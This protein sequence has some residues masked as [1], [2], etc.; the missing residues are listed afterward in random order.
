MKIVEMLMVQDNAKQKIELL[1]SVFA[2]ERLGFAIFKGL[3]P[4]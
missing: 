3:G 1:N 4:S 2:V